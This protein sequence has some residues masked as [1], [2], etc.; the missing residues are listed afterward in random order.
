M[1]ASARATYLKK[2]HEDTRAM[3]ERQVHRRATKLNVNKAPMVFQPGDL[4]WL[5]LRK[6]RF[7]LERKSKLLP[8]ADGP[9]KVLARYND[10]AY[11]IDIPRD[12][13]SVSDT[14]KVKDL[15]PFHGDEDFD[16]RSDLSQGRG[17]DAEH[18]K[19]IPMDPPS[20]HQV[21]KGPMTRARERALE[22]E[23]TSLLSLHLSDSLETW[24]LPSSGTM[25]I[26]RC[27]D[28]G[29]GTALHNGQDDRLTSTRDKKKEG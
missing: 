28:E 24:L 2:V 7:P 13:Y 21:P 19:D 1:D 16:P 15:S 12:K 9:F 17:D 26:F 4:V 6:D 22:T 10:N 5:H 20:P 25:C 14:F 11:K 18:P 8:R 3:I 29:H 23:E 27:L